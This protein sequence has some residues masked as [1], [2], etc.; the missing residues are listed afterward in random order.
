[1][2][3]GNACDVDPIELVELF[4]E[5]PECSIISLYLEGVNDG[6]KFVRAVRKACLKKPVIIWKVGLTEGGSRAVGSHTGSMGGAGEIWEGALSQAGATLV[7]SQE[8]LLDAIHAFHNIGEWTGEGIGF[9]G[10]GGAMSAAAA[11]ASSVLSDLLFLLGYQT[12]Q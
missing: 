12:K 6:R 10:G 8:E 11:D 7:S 2:S 4:A 5:D 3:V 1:M 9:V